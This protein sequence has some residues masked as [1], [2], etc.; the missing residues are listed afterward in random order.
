MPKRNA[1]KEIDD[2]ELRRVVGERI[3]I[4]GASA[5]IGRAFARRLAPLARTLV[6]VA[7]D[8]D[9]LNALSEELR[10]AN[11]ELGVDVVP[12]DLADASACR[13]VA[14]ALE[15]RAIDLLV[16][17]AGFGT[18]GKFG[19]LPIEEEVREVHTN[20]LAPLLLTR[21]CLPGMVGRGRGAVINVSSLAGEFPSPRSATYGATKAFLTHFSESLVEELRGSGVRIQA[22]LPGF[23]RTE[24]QARARIDTT[25]LPAFVWMS[26]ED[27]VDESLRAL[28]RGEP[29][30]VPGK[31]YRAFYRFVR[32][33][34]RTWLRRATGAGS[35][36]FS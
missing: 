7:R 31:R 5:G 33:T 23:T 26:A 8:T 27:V 19:D 17:N 4:T 28:A 35:E 11:P 16:N 6:L 25:R 10:R 36:R 12:G 2:R 34:P 22:L 29:L 14:T 24:F 30:C 13:S 15:G 32:A 1:E 20:A 9:R 18:H 21:A 3:A